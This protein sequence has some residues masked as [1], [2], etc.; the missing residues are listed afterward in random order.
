MLQE[1]SCGGGL[2]SRARFCNNPP[3]SGKG[4]DCVGPSIETRRC[5]NDFC[6][7][8]VMLDLCMLNN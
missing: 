1:E 6:K 4:R 3:P 2:K 8:L 5:S 7:G